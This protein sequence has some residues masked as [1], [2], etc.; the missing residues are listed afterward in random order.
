[1]SVNI[2]FIA[3]I[4]GKPG[5]RAVAEIVPHLISQYK[6]QLCIANGENAAGGFGITER[7]IRELC[8]SGV[9]VITSG[10]HLWDRR[11]IFDILDQDPCLLRPANYPPQVPGRGSSVFRALGDVPV[12]VLNLQGRVFMQEIDCPFRVADRE[13]ETLR[14]LTKVIVVDMHAEA[15]SEKV[16]MGYY[17]DG[18]VSAVIGT[19][20]HVQTADACILPGGTAYITDAG[21]TG[22]HDSIIGIKKK[23]ILRRFLTQLPTRFETATGDIKLCGVV[24]GVDEDTGKA[25][26]VHRLRI[27]LRD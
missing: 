24:V 13:L 22:P 4:V 21:M 2:L 5:R 11:E 16:A 3:D 27:N 9:D 20:T 1:M 23:A 10:N 26:A 12:G 19:H 18:Q 17:L 8:K 15:T 7:V 25:K 14:K 6:L